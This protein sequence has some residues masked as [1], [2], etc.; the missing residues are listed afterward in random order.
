MSNFQVEEILDRLARTVPQVTPNDVAQAPE[1]M[2]AIK[3]DLRSPLEM[4]D[5]KIP[6]A[7]SVQQRYIELEIGK[8]GLSLDTLIIVYCVG[9]RNSLFAA[10]A[11]RDL[12]YHNVYSL[13]GGFNA[14]RDAQLP[15][16]R[17]VQLSEA[18]QMRYKR[19]LML[20]KIGEEGQI[21][22]KRARVAIIGAGG[23][24]S[25]V[26]YYLAAAGVGYLRIIDNDNVEESNLQRQILHDTE[27]LG[28][29][30]VDS[31]KEA[32]QRFNPL[33]TVDAVNSR[34]TA[35]NAGRLL[36]GVDIVVDGSDNFATRYVVNDAIIVHRQTLVSASVFQFSGQVASFAPHQGGACYACL[37]P[38]Q[39]P[40]S[41]APSCTTAGVLGAHVGVV[42]LLQALEVIKEIL[43]IGE[44]LRHKLLVFDGMTSMSKLLSFSRR[45]GCMAC[46]PGSD[47][48][49][50]V[51]SE[52]ARAGDMTSSY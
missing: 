8:H 47:A 17:L 20:P 35:D 34:L 18:E 37:F 16:E 29:P 25:P 40:A 26:A 12:G 5:G 50:L 32:L 24:G 28:Q 4:A 51:S 10:K 13:A 52:H 22:L 49:P 39:P 48:A 38:E 14:W 7:R 19:Q 42:G 21:K 23:L 6:N 33:I 43:G 9:G 31:A 45:A 30:K 36:E 46:S 41:L 44:R 15:T 1:L 11:L 27:H 2:N 3:F